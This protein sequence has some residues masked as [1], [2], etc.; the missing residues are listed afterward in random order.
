MEIRR[1]LVADSSATFS[2]MFIR[3]AAEL[4]KDAVVTCVA[5][6]DDALTKIRRSDF[7]IIVVDAEVQD[8]GI[9]L[10]EISREIPKAFVLFTARSSHSS[11][12]LCAEALAYGAT[13][14][15]TK[16][17][18]SS[19]E[20]NYNV[21]KQKMA[22]M[23]KLLSKKKS[24]KAE[25]RVP[26][27]TADKSGACKRSFQPGIVLIAAST[28]GPLALEAIIPNLSEGFPA[29]ILVVQH[30]LLQ[31]TDSLAQNLN[32]K[33]ALR[34]KVAEN[35]EIAEAGTVYIAPG[36]THM[37]L[38]ANN[39][40]LLDKSPP[41]NGVRP[42]ADT[43]FESVADSYW[44]SGVLAIILTGMGH[45]GVKGLALL[46]EKKDCFC[47]AQ[48]EDTCVV[49]GMPRSAVE[50]GYADKVLDLNMISHEIESFK[51]SRKRV[52]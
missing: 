22:D 7:E 41:I 4:D 46:K 8:V 12:E 47:L 9:L 6:G 34:V 28:G 24:M 37:K 17:I 40:V 18:Q 31:F 35:G 13:D 42:A 49:Y 16:P 52:E 1:I 51:Y 25:Q 5:N 15:L 20:E 21:I 48:S 33:A 32:Q 14:Y 44:G 27:L 45:D 26:D 30:M 3:A 19:Y 38:A 43:L 11:D 29:P 23:L 39:M 10:K 2:K 50:S 36:G